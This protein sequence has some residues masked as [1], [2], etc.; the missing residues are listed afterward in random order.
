MCDFS[1]ETMTSELL[2][3]RD[4]QCSILVTSPTAAAWETL[5]VVS[6][7][8]EH[9]CICVYYIYQK[10]SCRKSNHHTIING[11]KF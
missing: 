10:I 3:D 5:G 6:I 8:R 7:R 1:Y 2:R 11:S 4:T 9:M